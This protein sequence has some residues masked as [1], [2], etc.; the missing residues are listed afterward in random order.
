VNTYIRLQMAEDVIVWIYYFMSHQFLWT[1]SKAYQ[2]NYLYRPSMP[3][4]NS[5][6]T[7]QRK[8][9][10]PRIQCRGGTR[11]TSPLYDT[12]H[13]ILRHATA[14][15]NNKKRLYFVLINEK[16]CKHGVSAQ[17]SGMKGLASYTN[18]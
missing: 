6:A 9:E 13:F 2:K 11:T 3:L 15:I 16:T 10:N 14:G 7:D 18:E 1:F 17:K 12:L 4:T 8:L 5:M